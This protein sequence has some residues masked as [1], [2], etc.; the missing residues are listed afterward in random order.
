MTRKKWMFTMMATRLAVAMFV[1]ILVFVF[2]IDNSEM[3]D[4]IRTI[5]IVVMVYTVAD[6]GIMLV[7]SGASA[8]VPGSWPPGNAQIIVRVR[9]LSFMVTAY[10]TYLKAVK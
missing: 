9:V 4:V 10:A 6:V 3:M 8:I 2:K 5:G 1:S 7:L